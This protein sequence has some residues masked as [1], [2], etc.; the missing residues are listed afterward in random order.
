MIPDRVGAVVNPQ[1]GDGDAAQ[2]FGDLVAC[3]PSASVEAQITTGPGDVPRAAREQ[4]GWADVLVVIGGDGTIREVVAALLEDETDQPPIFIVPAGR[5]NSVYR[6]LYGTSDWREVARGVADE[7]A[8][9]PLEAGRVSS[10]PAID[11]TYFVLG[12]TAGLFRSALDGADRLRFLPGPIA[13]LCATAQATL[14]ADPVSVAVAV[15]DAPV[16]D[17]DAR[18]VAVGGGRYRGQNFEL[19]PTSRVGDETLHVVAV[20]PAGLK[21]A[22]QLTRFA[23]AGRLPDHPAVHTASGHQATIA[24]DTGLPVEMDGT[25]ID[26]TLQTAALEVVPHAVSVAYPHDHPPQ[27]K[28]SHG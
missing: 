10:T 20:E 4:A 24:A 28:G 3:F 22:V 15:D 7:T 1:A 2:L 19:F 17:G 23:R 13:Y 18:L 6:H 27:V 9:Y 5:G 8:V 11:A 25:P 21:G 14:L 12:F 16:F 26:Q